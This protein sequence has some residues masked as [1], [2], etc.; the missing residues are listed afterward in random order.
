MLTDS[1]DRH[2]N[3]KYNLSFEIVVVASTKTDVFWV[4]ASA[5]LQKFIDVSEVPAASIIRVMHN[6]H[7]RNQFK[8]W[9]PV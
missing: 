2:V 1:L 9:E 8:I 6:L 3:N 4:L 5:V 7:T